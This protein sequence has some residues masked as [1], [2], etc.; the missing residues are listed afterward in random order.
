MNESGTLVA[1]I[2]QAGAM[3]PEAIIAIG[4]L[5]MTLSQIT[6]RVVPGDIDEWAPLISVFWAMIGAS[7]WFISQ[8]HPPQI[9]DSF[10]IAVGLAGIMLTAIGSYEA[11]KMTT[12]TLS[13]GAR[14]EIKAARRRGDD[15]TPPEI[16]PVPVPA[17]TRQVVTPVADPTPAERLAQR[18]PRALNREAADR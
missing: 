11:A 5:V 6:K 14:K 18:F 7:L 3:P 1:T 15:V 8:P 13:V 17:G 12:K 2:T 16:D 4:G 9:T 10:S